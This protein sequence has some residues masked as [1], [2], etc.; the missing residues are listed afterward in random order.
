MPK[1][2]KEKLGTIVVA[3]ALDAYR[4][5]A[6]SRGAVVKSRTAKQL[7]TGS[8]CG[9]V[10]CP[11]RAGYLLVEQSVWLSQNSPKSPIDSTNEPNSIN[12]FFMVAVSQG[13]TWHEH[14]ARGN[15]TISF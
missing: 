10:A 1:K 5:D 12:E 8:S 6:P 15:F 3:S 2:R 7:S 4:P 11:R 9:Q 14:E 13:D